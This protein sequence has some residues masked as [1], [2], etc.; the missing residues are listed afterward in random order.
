MRWAACLFFAICCTPVLHAQDVICI[1]KVGG[2][3]CEP[4]TLKTSNGNYSVIG[5]ITIKRNLSWF[6]AFD[7]NGNKIVN[8]FPAVS[9]GTN[10]PTVR[11]YKLETVYKSS[12]SS[13]DEAYN[14]KEQPEYDI[15]R[16]ER[17]SIENT[18]SNI[19]NTMNAAAVRGMSM[20]AAGYPNLTLALGISRMYGEFARLK[21][22][23]GGG[24]GFILYGG[25]GKD[26][27]F[28]GSNKDKLSW[29]TGLGYYGSWGMDDEQEF[30]LGI[31]VSETSAC[32]GYALSLD[33]AY[34]YYFG[35]ST[36]FGA[37]G[38]LGIGV[39]NLKNVYKSEKKFGGEF[40]WDITFGLAVK[41]FAG[42]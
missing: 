15:D 28:N 40:V 27:I 16:Q 4:V 17:S 32:P 34:S 33:L 42:K 24:G 8:P 20:H 3:I 23:L 1:F 31:T 38:G 11:T 2:N 21:A 12:K 18:M 19:G 25:V 7:C 39:G 35:S 30:D 37:F 5:S 14:Q 41:L 36:R 9:T 26:W 10:K 13:Y 22:C 29:H 6:E